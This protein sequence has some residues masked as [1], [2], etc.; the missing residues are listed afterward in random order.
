MLR[1]ESD[2][3]SIS[4]S[5]AAWRN[6]TSKVSHQSLLLESESHALCAA[7]V[8]SS[9]ASNN[10]GMKIS[11]KVSPTITGGIQW[12]GWTVAVPIGRVELDREDEQALPLDLTEREGVCLDLS[13][14]RGDPRL[15]HSPTGSFRGLTFV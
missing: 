11:L 15:V 3:V 2:I 14:G 5:S 12:I 6:E 1:A 13:L 10:N 7:G 4:I 8:R 9:A